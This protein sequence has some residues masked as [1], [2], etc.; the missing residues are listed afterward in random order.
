[1]ARHNPDD[2]SQRDV[3]PNDP[4]SPSQLDTQLQAE[5]DMRDGRVTSG[6][7]ALFA[8]AIVM[9]FAAVLYGMGGPVS[10]PTNPSVATKTSPQ[11]NQTDANNNAPPVPPGVR[12]VTP[13]SGD[14]NAQSGVTTGAAPAPRSAPSNAN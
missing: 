7:L 14:P 2:L 5:P 4:R 12:D 10:G 9:V 1:M 8:I 13:R 6:R 11:P 3:E